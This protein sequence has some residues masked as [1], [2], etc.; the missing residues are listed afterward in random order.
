[1]L[2]FS[3]IYK[4]FKVLYRRKSLF[5]NIISVKAFGKI[6]DT[7]KVNYES[8]LLKY[9][10]T[11]YIMVYK[12][13][14]TLVNKNFNCIIKNNV[15]TSTNKNPLLSESIRNDFYVEGLSKYAPQDLTKKKS[16]KIINI[17]KDIFF[18]EIL[19]NKSNYYHF[20]VDS[21]MGLIFFLEKYNKDFVILYNASIS[22]LIN[23]YLELISTVYKKKLIKIY[24]NENTISIKNNL[25]FVDNLRYTRILLDKKKNKKKNNQFSSLYKF[26]HKIKK[27]N[28]FSYNH[29][30]N[31]LSPSE[32]FNNVDNFIK[33]LLEKKI[34]KKKKKEN[35]YIKRLV[36]KG[37]R[38]RS[39]FNEKKL[40]DT[41]KEK[42][43]KI[44]YFDNMSA[45]EQIELMVNS[46]IVISVFGSNL[47]NT[48]F[49]KRGE[50]VIEFHP[51]QIFKNAD[52]FRYIGEQRNLNYCLLNCDLN[53]NNEMIINFNELD[54]IF[55]T[56]K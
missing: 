10:F 22:P 17:K 31:I 32:S 36:D 51:H 41:L 3:K 30:I 44:I 35:Y 34:I 20:V 12:L 40:I 21:F 6:T 25:I 28:T 37:Y 39:I 18:F 33:R 19:A 13:S 15:V 38:N 54:K 7:Y 26:T 23:T 4:F 8:K 50:A 55:N 53:S 56:L 43:F 2:L 45:I 5:L 27:N 46:N 52:H 29:S 47:T 1:M 11:D 9:N 24:K 14:D 49:K 42:D 16:D 48:I